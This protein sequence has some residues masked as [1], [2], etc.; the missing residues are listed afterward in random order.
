MVCEEIINRFTNKIQQYIELKEH[1][2]RGIKMPKKKTGLKSFHFPKIVHFGNNNK[3]QQLA[4]TKGW[5]S[6]G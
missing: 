3:H 2:F 1:Y 4:I 5:D 6:L